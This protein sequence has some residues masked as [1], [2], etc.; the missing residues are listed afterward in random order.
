[1][2]PN[3]KLILTIA[4]I[5]IIGCGSNHDK[6]EYRIPDKYIGRTLIIF[7]QNDGRE[8]EFEKGRRVYKLG[9]NGIFTT[10]F[11]IN[12]GGFMKGDRKFYYV[13]QNNEK[14]KEIK[15]VSTFSLFHRLD[16]PENEK[17]KSQIPLDD[18]VAVTEGIIATGSQYDTLLPK[19]FGGHISYVRIDTF[20]NLLK[21]QRPPDSIY[22]KQWKGISNK[23]DK[24]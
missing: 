18:I 12:P 10:Q 1:M 21:Y 6:E 22:Y 13:N 15:W 23:G 2:K 7:N 11:D 17:N 4:T 8:K 5:L 16:D 14:K 20:K 24:K 19:D 9:T 3:G